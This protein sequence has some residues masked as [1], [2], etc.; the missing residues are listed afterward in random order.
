M[1]D[2]LPHPVGHPSIARGVRVV[3]AWHDALNSGDVER[4]VALSHPDIR[5]VGSK[6]SGRGAQLLREWAVR[7]GIQ[8]TLVRHFHVG[9]TVV[10]GQD[11]RWRSAETGELSGMQRVASTFV[12]RGGRVASV[13]RYADL[14]GALRDAGL[15]ESP[16]SVGTGGE[17]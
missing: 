14:S 16:V 15:D 11:A 9:R 3:E 13:S 2:H 10:V 1:S 5:V 6:G 4:L 17:G 7:A 12:V 8:L